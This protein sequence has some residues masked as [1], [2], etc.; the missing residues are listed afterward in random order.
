MEGNNN[1]F[2]ID[3]HTCLGGAW[4]LGK[5]LIQGREFCGNAQGRA[6]SGPPVQGKRLD[7]DAQE[8]GHGSVSF[9][10]I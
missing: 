8:L 7:W 3:L 5:L 4:D 1:G 6:A 2:K 9:G 10:E